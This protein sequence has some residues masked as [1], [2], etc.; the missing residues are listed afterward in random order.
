MM[1]VVKLRQFGEL[2]AQQGL[3][4]IGGIRMLLFAD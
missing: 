1:G 4:R 2:L 3:A